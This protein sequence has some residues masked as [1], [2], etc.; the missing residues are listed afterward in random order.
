MFIIFP[1]N[2]AFCP[3]SPGNAG[4]SSADGLQENMDVGVFEAEQ[5]FSCTLEI[6]SSSVLQKFR[7]IGDVGPSLEDQYLNHVQHLWT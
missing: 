6:A 1:L 7:C 2:G 3:T 4:A 5:E